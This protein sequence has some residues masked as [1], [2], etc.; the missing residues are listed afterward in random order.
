MREIDRISRKEILR[1][2]II[3]RDDEQASTLKL[4]LSHVVEVIL[5]DLHYDVHQRY[6]GLACAHVI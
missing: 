4:L 3:D 2:S 1:S 5:R 6:L